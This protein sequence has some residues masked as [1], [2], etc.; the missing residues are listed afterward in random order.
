MVYFLARVFAYIVLMPIFFIKV[1]DKKN[2][3]IKSGAVVICNHQ[4]NWDPII[5]G[6]SIKT[7]P[8]CYTVSYT[9]LDVYKRQHKF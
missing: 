4:S 8:V 1:I 9:H 6:H 7:Q 3:K 2:L 5:L